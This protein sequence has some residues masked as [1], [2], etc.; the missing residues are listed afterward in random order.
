MS[1]TLLRAL[2]VGLVAGLALVV[3]QA[4]L[5]WA[6]VRIAPA[7]AEVEGFTRT[8]L[9]IRIWGAPATIALY[10]LTGWLIALERTRE[11]L[12]GITQM[13]QR[14]QRLPARAARVLCR[15]DDGDG[16]RIE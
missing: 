12:A 4:P 15:A 6:A 9:A 3:L 16:L 5:I 7:T 8:Y 1:A 13:R 2:I 10:A 14:I 11:H